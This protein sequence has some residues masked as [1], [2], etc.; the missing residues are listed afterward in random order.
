MSSIS[1]TIL[2]D[3]TRYAGWHYDTGSEKHMVSFDDVALSYPYINLTMAFLTVTF[4]ISNSGS[5]CD[6]TTKNTDC[7]VGWT[8][9]G[10][11]TTRTSPNVRELVIQE[12]KFNSRLPLLTFYIEATCGTTLKS[13]FLTVFYKPPVRQGNSIA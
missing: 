12:L 13:A 6:I 7:W 10:S 5:K 8:S 9:E 3:G 2:Q 11:N 4:N 1:D